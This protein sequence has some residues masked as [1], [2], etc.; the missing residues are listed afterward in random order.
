MI[1]ENGHPEIE[2]IEILENIGFSVK[3][4]KK[5]PYDNYAL[6]LTCVK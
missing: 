2:I 4:S 3:K 5:K 6:L 1:M